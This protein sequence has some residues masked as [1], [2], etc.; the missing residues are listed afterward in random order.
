MHQM[1]T[2]L[3]EANWPNAS[4]RKKRGIPV[5]KMLRAYGIRKA[6]VK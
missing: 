3:W 2:G 4:S 6:P 5:K 1:E